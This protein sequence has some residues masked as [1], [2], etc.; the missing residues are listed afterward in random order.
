MRSMP[1]A[2]TQQRARAHRRGPAR[3]ARPNAPAAGPAA[4]AAAAAAATA[5]D[6]PDKGC[7]GRVYLAVAA[8]ACS[9]Y[10]NALHGD[11]V[12]DDIPAVTR[13]RDVVGAGPLADVF[14][15]DFWGTP[16]GDAA[17]HKSYRPLTTLTFR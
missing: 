2:D 1:G 12:H 8:V 6:H 15:D 14:R 5:R 9:C 7:G 4:Q 16:M 13:N 3:P 11:F 10:V 17:S